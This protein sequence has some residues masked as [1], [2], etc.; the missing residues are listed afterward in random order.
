MK[1]WRFKLKRSPIEISEKLESELKSI[2]G[3]VFNMNH[4]NNKSL[5]FKMRKRIL[6]A[7]YMAFQNWT[8]V[9]GELLNN[10]IENETNVKITFNQHFFI[11]LIIYTHIILVF[12]FLIAIISGINVN[13]SMYILVGSL[14]ILGIVLWLAIQRKFEKDIQKYK[15]LITE[16]FEIQ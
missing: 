6:Y 13:A 5:T 14:L 10:D 2:G 3:F 7:W 1:A 4:E 12:G 9:K 15:S 16:I 11:R 8:V